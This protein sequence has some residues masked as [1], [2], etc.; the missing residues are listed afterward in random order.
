MIQIWQVPS[1]C[2][3]S[4]LVVLALGDALC[5]IH[6]YLCP[7]IFW[8]CYFSLSQCDEHRTKFSQ[9][10]C[11]CGDC[12]GLA[13]VADGDGNGQQS[14]INR[15]SIRWQGTNTIIIIS[16]PHKSMFN[17]QNG[18]FSCTGQN[19][20]K[21]Y[22]CAATAAA[23]RWWR[24]ATATDSEAKSAVSAFADRA[25]LLLSSSQFHIKV[26]S[27]CR[28]DNFHVPLGNRWRSLSVW[29]ESYRQGLL[30]ILDILFIRED[31]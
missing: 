18:Q 28:M 27:I 12:G 14:K 29:Y 25:P 5:E 13:V 2:G 20:L 21:T 4:N 26:C 23:R 3:P 1:E 19:F 30:K 8:V 7:H 10:V 6:C 31:C 11:L 24:T 15:V 16:V 22:V 17:M 9:N